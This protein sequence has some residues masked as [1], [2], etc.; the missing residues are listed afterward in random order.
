MI[1]EYK[2]HNNPENVVD[3]PH[4]RDC[5]Y[6]GGKL[7]YIDLVEDNWNISDEVLVS[8]HNTHRYGYVE[9]E[10]IDQ[11]HFDLDLDTK[12]FETWLDYCDTC[13]WWRIIKDFKVCAEV[14]QLWDIFF[15]CIGTLKNLEVGNLKTPIEEVSKFLIAKY[16]SRF[17][18]N[19]RLFEE[20][21]G[22]VF[23]NMGYH[24]HVTGYSNDG[25]IDVV[26]NNSSEKPIGIQV[27]RYKNKIKVEQIRSFAGALLLNG[28]NKGVFVTTSDYQPGAL[29]AAKSFTAKTLPI[30][31]MNSNKFYDALKISQKSSF[32]PERIIEMIKQNKI[33]DLP[34]YGWSTPNAS[35]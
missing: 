5:I 11:S 25:G 7:K 14:H 16:E 23:K 15:G 20:V 2:H 13:G 29:D 21:V 1:F 26:L 4:W 27:K 33:K 34:Y 19:P 12:S 10:G 35:L 22:S 9:Q 30:T 28:I 8:A 32:N 31:L 17:S 18:V 6:C 24:V 3:S